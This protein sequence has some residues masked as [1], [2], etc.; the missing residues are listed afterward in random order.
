MIDQLKEKEEFIHIDFEKV[1]RYFPAN[2]PFKE[3]LKRVLFSSMPIAFKRLEVYQNW[4]NARIFEDNT[5]R[6][7]SSD[8]WKSKLH[9]RYDV[10]FQINENNGL[11]K[12]NEF[13]KLA[14]VVHA[15]YPEVLQGILSKLRESKPIALKLF[16][17]TSESTFYVVEEILVKSKFDY[18]LMKVDNRGRDVLPFLKTLKYV[19]DE[20]YTLVLKLH[21]KRSNHLHKKD[22]W[23][24]DLFR[25]LLG[26]ENMINIV[27]TFNQHEKLGMIGPSEHILPMSFYYGGNAAKVEMLG[28]KMGLQNRQFSNL[29]FPAGTMF[30]ARKE[31]L[32]PILNLNLNESDFEDEAGQLDCT[33]AH[34]VE[35]SFACSVIA[36]GM[37]LADSSSKP[38]MIRCKI[39]L[40]HSFTL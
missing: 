39:N 25:K 2:R 11:E 17:T 19:F 20:G 5:I 4:K 29:H 23:S 22:I 14:I 3:H 31:A 1:W 24:V 27:Q 9:Y 18:F 12:E 21:T 13:S 38:D 37:Y 40:N 28:K 30:Y 32:L 7:W 16:V 6:C 35:R 33:M 15:F 26:H 36:S 34:A 8:F 10:K